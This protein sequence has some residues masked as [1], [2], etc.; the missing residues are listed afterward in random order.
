[1]G[2]AFNWRNSKR[3]TIITS[4]TATS[5]KAPSMAR[6]DGGY[7]PL[8]LSGESVGSLSVF[9]EPKRYPLGGLPVAVGG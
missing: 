6:P 4:P 9:C 5:S 8:L 1:M 2:K 3:N 7:S